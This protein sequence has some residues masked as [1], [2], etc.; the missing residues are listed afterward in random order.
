MR[1]NW[2]HCLTGLAVAITVTLAAG[3]AILTAGL[4]SP[5]DGAIA[6][7]VCP[8]GTHWDNTVNECV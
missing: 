8:G 7:P 6:G 1:S 2:R 4:S 3:P 5:A